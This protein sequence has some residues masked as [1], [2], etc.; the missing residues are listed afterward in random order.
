M[1]NI[2]LIV[3]FGCCLFQHVLCSSQY[4]DDCTCEKNQETFDC[5]TIDGTTYKQCH[6]GTFKECTTQHKNRILCPDGLVYD[7]K[8]DPS[9]GYTMP[10]EITGD[11]WSQCET[12]DCMI[13]K[14]PSGAKFIYPYMSDT[15]CNPE[16]QYGYG[17]GYDDGYGYDFGYG[18]GYGGVY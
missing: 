11:E 5:G 9:H 15:Q 16:Y 13:Y 17:R 1:L 12:S 7:F 2:I 6:Q 4:V 3:I 18:Y 14:C 8:K 10:Y